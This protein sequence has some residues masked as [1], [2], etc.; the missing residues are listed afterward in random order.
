M[1]LQHGNAAVR[2]QMGSIS[3]HIATPNQA[4]RAVS[5]IVDTMVVSISLPAESP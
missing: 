4:R 3:S 5:A 1:Q 2:R